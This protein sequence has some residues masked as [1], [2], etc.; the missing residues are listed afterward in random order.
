LTALIL[1]AMP[2]VEIVV[3]K[4][5]TIYQGFLHALDAFAEATMC[6]AV[7]PREARRRDQSLSPADATPITKMRVK[8]LTPDVD[9][10]LIPMGRG[11]M[12]RGARVS[13]QSNCLPNG[14]RA[15]RTE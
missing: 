13:G 6:N 5:R 11:G 7:R 12:A 3:P 2:L 10:P 1:R 8:T 9:L 4:L 15:P 14:G